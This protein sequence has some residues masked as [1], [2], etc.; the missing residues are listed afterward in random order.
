[1][2]SQIVFGD[3]R[4]PKQCVLFLQVFMCI[5]ASFFGTSFVCY[6]LIL[7]FWLGL[8][9]V[10]SEPYFESSK[11][12]SNC[13]CKTKCVC[14]TLIFFVFGLYILHEIVWANILEV[15]FC[16]VVFMILKV[17]VCVNTKSL[18]LRVRVAIE[19]TLKVKTMIFNSFKYH[20]FGNWTQIGFEYPKCV[21]MLCDKRKCVERK[22][23]IRKRLG[24]YLF[25]SPPFFL[26]IPLFISSL[27]LLC[28]W[29][30]LQRGM[31]TISML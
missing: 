29:S 30:S 11:L 2:G 3:S 17:H 20:P 5:Y 7:Y 9:L 14:V 13:W 10:V 25:P 26:S 18:Q 23:K 16:F 19:K 31:T 1:M 27:F 8:L 28:C 21:R 15:S 4:S 6:V 24:L 22:K 12:M